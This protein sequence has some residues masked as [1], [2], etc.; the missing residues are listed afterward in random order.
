[1]LPGASPAFSP[2]WYFVAILSDNPPPLD[3]VEYDSEWESPGAMVTFFPSLSP[4]DQ[5]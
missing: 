3:L 1:M 5:K 4:Q 2:L